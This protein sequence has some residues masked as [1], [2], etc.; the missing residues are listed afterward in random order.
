MKYNYTIL[1][2]LLITAVLINVTACSKD[3]AEIAVIDPNCPD[4]ISFS[5]QI[6][7]LIILN[8]STSACHDATASG[9]YNM[10][11]HLNISSNSE[12]ILSAMKHE[13]LIPM[14]LG[15]DKLA[16]SLIQQ[17]ECWISQGLKDN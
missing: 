2:T 1:F 8:C 6:D 13:T 16:D 11:G 17:F 12:V 5:T 3:K 14:P 7:S 9:G 15:V 4:T 10:I